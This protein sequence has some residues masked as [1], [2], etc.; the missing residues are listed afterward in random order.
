MSR[1]RGTSWSPSPVSSVGFNQALVDFT[2]G[3]A[4]WVKNDYDFSYEN[5][6]Q[7]KIMESTHKRMVKDR[8]IRV[9]SQK[10]N[11]QVDV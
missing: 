3:Y 1:T 7:K 10:Q 11:I 8:T 4:F 6:L 2:L 5:Y 9:L